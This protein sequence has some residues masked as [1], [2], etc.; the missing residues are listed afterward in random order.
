MLIFILVHLKWIIFNN[1]CISFSVVYILCV[2]I[3]KDWLGIF[4]SVVTKTKQYSH[5]LAFF[6]LKNGVAPR[7]V[8][9]FYY[10]RYFL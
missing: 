8:F 9:K 7:D 10:V 1:H 3:C 5:S 6:F 4:C 2:H